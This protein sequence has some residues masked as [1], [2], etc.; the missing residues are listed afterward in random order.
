MYGEN[1]QQMIDYYNEDQ[2]RLTH[3]ELLVVEKMVQ[4]AVLDKASVTLKNKKFQE[5]TKQT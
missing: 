5:V 3:V 2:T 1:A 4:D